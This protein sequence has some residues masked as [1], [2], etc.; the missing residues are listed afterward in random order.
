MKV[1]NIIACVLFVCSAALQYN[2]EDPVLWIP[3]YLYGAWV[4]YLA[5]KGRYIPMAYAIGIGVYAA[6]VIYFLVFKHGVLDWVQHHPAGDLVK[7]MK[8]DQPWI[9]ETREVMGLLILIAV[10][11]INWLVASV[12]M[13]KANH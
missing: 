12:R 1:F 9:E 2:D 11:L 8:A 5:A 7:S 4:C 6:F 3:L 13:K 10:M